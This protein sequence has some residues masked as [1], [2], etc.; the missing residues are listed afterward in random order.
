MKSTEPRYTHDCDSCVFLGRYHN[1][2]KTFD[3]Y[4]CRRCDGGSLLAR[5]GSKDSSYMSAP[6]SV[7]LY[8]GYE[9][10]NPLVVAAC[11]QIE[12]WTNAC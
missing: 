5:Y 2:G 10:N 11:R 4:Y 9:W 1:G 12:K 6:F 7:L 8:A 3:L